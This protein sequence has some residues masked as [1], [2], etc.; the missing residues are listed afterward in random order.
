MRGLKDTDQVVLVDPRTG[1]LRQ[2]PRSEAIRV[3]EHV[4]RWA[5][6]RGL[7]LALCLSLSVT[8]AVT[9]AEWLWAVAAGVGL[10]WAWGTR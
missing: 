4:E 8:A 6:W 1:E 9:G 10:A 5:L 3:L 7:G 2:M